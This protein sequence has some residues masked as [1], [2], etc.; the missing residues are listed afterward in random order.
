[1]DRK[2]REEQV[3]DF[4]SH[5]V[6]ISSRSYT[7]PLCKIISVEQD[8]FICTSVVPGQNGSQEKDFE[9]KGELDG[10]EWAVEEE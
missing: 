1:M 7:A 5:P 8:G 6:Y 2:L 4:V 3:I 9:D 10:G